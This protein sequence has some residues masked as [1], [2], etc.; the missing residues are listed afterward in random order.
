MR[1]V[2]AGCARGLYECEKQYS[3][4]SRKYDGLMLGCMSHVDAR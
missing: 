2:R 1:D 3:L 4:V